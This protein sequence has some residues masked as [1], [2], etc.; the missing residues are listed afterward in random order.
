MSNRKMV[1]KNLNLWTIY[2][3]PSDAPKH[4]VLRR[5]EIVG[6]QLMPREAT[7]H[8]SLVDARI[9]VPKGLIRME[10][11]EKDDATIVETYI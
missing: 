11:D 10:R 5:W 9:A 2:D 3:H 7:K 6:D 1:R 8:D 4:F